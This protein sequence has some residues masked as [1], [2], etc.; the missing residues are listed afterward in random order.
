MIANGAILPFLLF[1]MFVPQLIWIG[2][3]WAITF[4]LAMVLLIAAF[5]QIRVAEPPGARES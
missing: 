1:Q 2:A 3:L 4:P 5:R